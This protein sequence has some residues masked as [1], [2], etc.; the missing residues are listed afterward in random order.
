MT[1]LERRP[2]LSS[3]AGFLAVSVILLLFSVSPVASA[4][5]T[6]RGTANPIISIATGTAGGTMTAVAN[7]SSTIRYSH[8]TRI[9]KITVMTSCP[10]QNFGLQVIATGVTRGVAAPVVTLMDGMAAVDFITSIPT[11]GFTTSTPTLRYTA[12]ATFDQGN[13]AELGDDVH[14][15]TYTHQAQ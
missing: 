4:Q 13:S 2:D 6:L 11:S 5:L 1:M 3:R 12:T 9:S 10:S 15:V 14:M 7:T 8:Q